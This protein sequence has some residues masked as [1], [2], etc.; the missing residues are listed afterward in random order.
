MSEQLQ[1]LVLASG[2]A[3]KIREFSQLLAPL[4]FEVIPQSE[5][6]VSSVPET[7][8][9]FVENAII[10]ARHAA[11]ETGLPALADDSGI[12]VDALGGN[13]GIYSARF[14]GESASDADNNAKLLTELENTPDAERTARFHCLLVFIRHAEDPTPIICDGT[15]E[16]SIL[17]E[18]RGEDGFGYDPLFWVT[19]KN[20]ASA[21]L[22]KAEK[23]AISHRGKA[24]KA[25]LEKLS[26]RTN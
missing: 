21:E 12:A 23:N 16:G 11:K 14:A 6:G 4:G 15:W 1:K 18:A 25:L 3:G 20:C 7:G 17:R 19:E 26:S 13:P 8:L 9:T 10:K 5:L 22:E 24:M 2:N